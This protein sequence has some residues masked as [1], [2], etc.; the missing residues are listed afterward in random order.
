M[1]RFMALSY[2]RGSTTKKRKK[3]DYIVYGVLTCE[4]I[5]RNISQ[6][7]N[8][9]CKDKIIVNYE[10]LFLLQ[11]ANDCRKNPISDISVKN[12]LSLSMDS[13]TRV[14]QSTSSWYSATYTVAR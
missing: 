5:D 11:V 13:Q 10:I 12:E 3:R 4:I 8:W 6:K 14:V 1:P 2:M 7:L 9:F